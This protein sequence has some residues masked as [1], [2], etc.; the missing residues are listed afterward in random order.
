[1]SIPRNL[2]QLADNYNP[3]TGELNVGTQMSGNGIMQNATTV[4]S[5]YTIGPGY[6]GFSVGPITVAN[7]ISVTVSNG[8]RWVVF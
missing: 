1:M 7:G 2:S 8:Q 5:N 4:S 6:N 3:I